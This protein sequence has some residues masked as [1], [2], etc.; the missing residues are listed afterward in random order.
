MTPET[1]DAATIRMLPAPLEMPKVAERT[2]G[3]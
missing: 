3:R 1:A 2:S